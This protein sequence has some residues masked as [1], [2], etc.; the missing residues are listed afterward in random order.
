MDKTDRIVRRF[1]GKGEPPAHVMWDGKDEAGLPLPDGAYHYVLTVNDAEGRDDRRTGTHGRD[2]HRRTARVR[3]RSRSTRRIG[4][5][6]DANFKKPLDAR[7]FSPSPSALVVSAS[8]GGAEKAGF[9][10]LSEI[11][12]AVEA[13]AR[14]LAVFPSVPRRWRPPPPGGW[15]RSSG[16]AGSG[17]RKPSGPAR[18]LHGEILYRPGETTPKKPRRSSSRR[19]GERGTQ[20]EDTRPTLALPRSRPWRLWVRMT[21]RRPRPGVNW[22]KDHGIEPPSTPKFTSGPGLERDPPELPG[23]GGEGFSRAASEGAPLAPKE[24]PRFVLAVA[25]AAYLED[26]PQDALAVL[27]RGADDAPTTYLT[28]LCLS[29]VGEVLKA[30]ARFQEAAERHSGFPSPG[31]CASGQGKH[32]PGRRCLPERRG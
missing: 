18:F 28:A 17:E 22:E 16:Q 11:G 15:T 21:R 25:T 10:D 6:R 5:A 8:A 19:P 20:D 32:V 23:R 26:R 14:E 7:S 12:I 1:G 31:L 13:A 24:D 2:H 29:A 27:E 3:F 9:P 4:Y 30:A